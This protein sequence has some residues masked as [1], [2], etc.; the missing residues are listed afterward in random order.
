MKVRHPMASTNTTRGPSL[1]ERSQEWV[2]R[3]SKALKLM[4]VRI[5][6]N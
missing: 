5:R 6:S 3:G 4:A 2:L 1:S